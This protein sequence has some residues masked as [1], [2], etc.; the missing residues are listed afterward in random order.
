MTSKPANYGVM[1]HTF[2]CCGLNAP[3]FVL[4]FLLPLALLPSFFISLISLFIP[5]V[6]FF[7]SIEN[8][9]SAGSL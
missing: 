9:C 4:I 1:G 3:F 5:C 2:L 7:S 6:V 8:S